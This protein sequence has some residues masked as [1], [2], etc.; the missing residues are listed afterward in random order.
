MAFPLAADGGAAWI[1]QL[2]HA[3]RALGR[4]PLVL[5]AARGAVASAFGLRP[6]LELIDLLEGKRDFDAV[7]QVTPDGVYLLRADRGVEAFVAGGAPAARLLAGFARLS[8]GFDE[9]L[10]AMPTGELACLAGGDDTVPVIGL[11]PRPYGTMRSYAVIKQLSEGFGYRRFTCV[12][13]DV[14][15]LAQ[16]RREYTRLAAAAGRF[17]QAD[18]ALAGWLPSSVRARPSALAR[19]ARTL[20]ET[21]VVPLAS[22]SLQ[23]CAA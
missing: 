19:V 6:R 18:V 12:M 2:A 8:H 23:P 22:Q 14:G 7:A 17:L 15:D 13:H 4:R 21:A 3:L 9:L 10:L 1:A 20:L 16:A 11:D 5:D